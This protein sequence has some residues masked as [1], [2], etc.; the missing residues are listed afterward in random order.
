M[1]W[2]CWRVRLVERFPLAERP[3]G[4]AANSHR[5]ISAYRDFLL[6]GIRTQPPNRWN[7]SPFGKSLV[8]ANGAANRQSHRVH[9]SFACCEIGKN[10]FAVPDTFSNPLQ[11]NFSIEVGAARPYPNNPET[12]GYSRC[13]KGPLACEASLRLTYYSAISRLSRQIA[14]RFRSM[15]RHS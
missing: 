2:L 8:I 9:I 3:F 7:R 15:S 6:G 11:A 13:H 1:A 5:F 14:S 10:I 12:R 4:N